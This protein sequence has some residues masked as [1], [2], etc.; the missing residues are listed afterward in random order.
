MSNRRIA[1]SPATSR[2]SEMAEA[3]R[4]DQMRREDVPTTRRSGGMP[5]P[6]PRAAWRALGGAASI[7]GAASILAASIAGAAGASAPARAHAARA[8]TVN[9]TG[10]LHLLKSTG[11]VLIEEGPVS[12]TLPGTAKVRMVIEASV[13]ASFTIEPRGGGSIVG[14]GL[15][16][17]HSSGRFSSFAGSLSVSHGSGRY[18]RA[19]GKGRLYGVLNR[20]T[21]QLT[22]QT[23][24][25]LS[26]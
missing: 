12:G 15:A 13:I 19:H 20:R 8:L 9:D 14:N 24:G 11:S 4:G 10:H 21:D 17:P 26:Y 22:V 1:A 7:V 3:E 6:T 2:T 23:V 18:S 25:K 16:T 5:V